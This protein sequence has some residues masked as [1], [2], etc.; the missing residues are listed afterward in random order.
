MMRKGVRRWFRLPVR[1]R[2]L[3]EADVEAEL[4]SHIEE[5]VER[6]MA[7]GMPEEDARAEAERRLGGLAHARGVLIR[8]AWDRDIRLS[9]RDRFRELGDDV[10]YALR[11]VTRERG[12]AAVVI[13]TLALGIGANATMFGLLDRLLL[14]GPAHVVEPGDV[15][16][17]Y[18]NTRNEHDGSTSRFA[19]MHGPALMHL[20]S[21]VPSM[22]HASGYMTQTS[23]LGAGVEARQLRLDGVSA[24][25]FD[26]LGVRPAL[27]R[28]FDATEDAPPGGER[29]IVLSHALWQSEFGGRRDVTGETMM[30]SGRPYII[31]GV[32]PAGF[33]G[34]LLEP[35]DGWVPLSSTVAA[36]MGER[37]ATEIMGLYLPVV[38]RLRPGADPE[39]AAAEATAAWRASVQDWAETHREAFITLH[40]MRADAEGNE[41]MEARVARWLMAVAVVVLLVACANVANLYFARG[42]RRRRE[43]AVRLAMGISRGRLLRLLLA[44]SMLLA[45]LGGIAALAVAYWGASIVRTVLLPDFDWT[46]SP[47]DGRVLAV[48]A[49][50][51]LLVGVVTGLAPALLAGRPDLA[52]AL[53]GSV[54]APPAPGRARSVLAVLQAAFCVLLLVGAGVFVRSLWSVHEMNL[55]VDTDRVMAVSFEWQTPPDLGDAERAELT[56]RRRAFYGEAAARLVAEPGVDAASVAV[57]SAFGG[58]YAANVRVA[59]VD[60]IPSMPGGGPYMSA[61]SADYFATLGTPVLRGRVFT[62]GEGAGTDPVI[63]LSRTTAEALWPGADPLGQCVHMGTG[64]DVPCSRVV[65]VVADTR[66]FRIVEDAAL[67]FY[68]PLGQQ[69]AWMAGVTLLARTSVRPE[70]MGEPLRRVLYGLEPS[71]RFVNVRPFS[72]FL[73]PQRRPWK[74]GATLFA[75]CGVLALVI[76]ALGLYS[77]IAYLVLHRRHEIGVRMALGARRNDVMRLVLR[78]SLV[79]TGVGVAIGVVAALLAAPHLEPLL[80][81]TSA[82]D[83]AVFAIVAATLVAAAVAAGMLPAWRASRVEPTEALRD[84]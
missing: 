70:V 38:A 78:Q 71:L 72:E 36:S 7:A 58:A 13:I 48:S 52:P 22:T 44:E 12:Y 80:F 40:P 43:I 73:E 59:G 24:S 68:V 84:S 31:V 81:E 83:P 15:Y 11:S 54:H 51:T 67:Q 65:G 28:F 76:A 47:L 5:R 62:A 18:V 41:P 23:T 21:A 32:A 45:V 3:T 39:R 30:L 75:L 64:P 82:V 57:G 69:P 42:L 60:S 19:Q 50:V 77:V 1:N 6:L 26:L 17:F 63:V 33:T 46:S 53:A 4:T 56:A 37:W 74:L 79:L 34:V 61:V 16:R 25:F 55:G 20:R 14:S 8:D 2:V 29:V 49:V 35:R 27:G 10:A 9:L 66:R